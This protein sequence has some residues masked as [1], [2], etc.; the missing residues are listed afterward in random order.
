ML[1][2]LKMSRERSEICSFPL[3]TTEGHSGL[4]CEKTR[5]DSGYLS[6]KRS[7]ELQEAVLLQVMGTLATKSEF[8]RGPRE[9]KGGE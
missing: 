3:T 5:M 8:F 7:I 2:E 9:R 1:A 4:N 6:Q